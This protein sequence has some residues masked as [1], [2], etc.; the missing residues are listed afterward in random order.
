MQATSF[1]LP[2]VQEKV[3]GW[4]EAPHSLPGLCHWDF[5]PHND[6]PH[7][8]DFQKKRKEE[9][10][11]LAYAL[12][13]SADRFGMPPEVLCEVAQDLQRCMVPLMFLYRDEIVEFSLFRPMSKEHRTSSTPQEGIVLLGTEPPSQKSQEIA[14][15]LCIY[16]KDTPKPKD[17]V[18]WSDAPCQAVPSVVAPR[19]RGDHSSTSRRTQWRSRS[20]CP[21]SLDLADDPMTGS[22]PTWQ[23]KIELP[24]WWPQFW[25]HCHKGAGPLS[26]TNV[27]ELTRKQAV[28]FRLPAA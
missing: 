27:Q 1:W 5:L 9:T 2:T 28:G 13:H 3:S 6:V 21:A 8:R 25:S 20:Q 24:R 15:L 26:N 18:E 19:N 12:Q 23:K 4:W 14:T 16:Q 10:S 7:T 17:T 22:L 11:A